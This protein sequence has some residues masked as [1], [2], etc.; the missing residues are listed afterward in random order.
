MKGRKY[1][2]PDFEMEVP[3]GASA[4]SVCLSAPDPSPSRILLLAASALYS[5]VL[6][7]VLL[8]LPD[9]VWPQSPAGGRGGRR[10]GGYYSTSGDIDL[11]VRTAPAAGDLLSQESD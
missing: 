11:G 5:T 9:S 6:P 4:G 7:A 3:G 8:L 1:S 2:D 10:V